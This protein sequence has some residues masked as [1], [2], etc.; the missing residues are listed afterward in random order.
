MFWRK[1]SEEASGTGNRQ[2]ASLIR[3]QVTSGCIYNLPCAGLPFFLTGSQSN[4]QMYKDLLYLYMSFSVV[5]LLG[6][7]LMEYKMVMAKV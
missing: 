5:V 6:H 2:K 1:N 4:I 7:L 3:F